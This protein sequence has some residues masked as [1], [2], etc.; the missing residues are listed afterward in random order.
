VDILVLWIL[1]F[2]LC[3]SSTGTFKFNF[4]NIMDGMFRV[5]SHVWIIYESYFRPHF[6]LIFYK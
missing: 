6:A 2:V 5:S 4:Q 3:I 1:C